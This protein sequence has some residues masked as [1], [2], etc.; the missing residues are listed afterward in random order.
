MTKGLKCFLQA[1]AKDEDQK[2]EIRAEAKT[3]LYES[4]KNKTIETYGHFLTSQYTDRKDLK[5][6]IRKRDK[7]TIVSE[8][9]YYEEVIKFINENWY[10]MDLI[11]DFLNEYLDEL[12][13]EKEEQEQ[14][15]K[16]E[17]NE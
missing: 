5:K 8:L 7:I 4:L 15:Q 10:E 2:P 17:T 11:M 1:L 16:E 9:D 12:E 13:K 3:H 6:A 14:K